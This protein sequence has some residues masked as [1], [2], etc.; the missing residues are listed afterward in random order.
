MKKLKSR[1]YRPTLL[2]LD[3]VRFTANL[4]SLLFEAKGYKTIITTRQ[5]DTIPIRDNTRQL[6]KMKMLEEANALKLFCFWAFGQ[7][8]TPTTANQNLVRQV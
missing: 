3:D 7:T 8:S 4:E 5:D 1:R 6:Y 2:V